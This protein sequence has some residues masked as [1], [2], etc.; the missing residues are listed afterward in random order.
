MIVTQVVVMD[1]Q[2]QLYIDYTEAEEHVTIWGGRNKM[3]NLGLDKFFNF[4][5]AMNT[6]TSSSHEGYA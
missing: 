5:I 1:G 3:G 6:Q 4:H 2:A